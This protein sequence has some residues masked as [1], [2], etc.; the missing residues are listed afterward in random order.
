MALYLQ[1]LSKPAALKES[2]LASL[3]AATLRFFDFSFRGRLPSNFITKDQKVDDR[4]ALVHICTTVSERALF[5]SG[6]HGHV[7]G[8]TDLTQEDDGSFTAYSEVWLDALVRHFSISIGDIENVATL[9]GVAALH[10][11]MHNKVDPVFMRAGT[12]GDIHDHG[13]G[14]IALGDL[15]KSVKMVDRKLV[16]DLTQINRNLI[17]AHFT[18]RV[19]QTQRTK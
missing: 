2:E 15:T 4:N 9:L 16:A 3:R 14:G 19:K 12:P 1:F 5:H 13:G 17:A 11:A 18:D 10:E 7:G 6:T 8:E